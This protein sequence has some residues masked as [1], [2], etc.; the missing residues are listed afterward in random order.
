M[1]GVFFLVRTSHL[2]VS[3]VSSV[4]W[5]RTR[6]MREEEI[7]DQIRLRDRDLSSN[8]YVPIILKFPRH[9]FIADVA[10]TRAR[11]FWKNF[12]TQ[13]AVKVPSSKHAM[14]ARW[15]QL[16]NQVVA[17]RLRPAEQTKKCHG[18]N[19]ILKLVQP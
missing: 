7:R 5:N 3:L 6:E 15:Q 12:A 18:S 13:S 2:I 17:R 10:D 11:K 9:V 4:E 1:Q 16:F 19:A 8:E 14:S